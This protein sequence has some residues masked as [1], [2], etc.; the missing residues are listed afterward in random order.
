[1]KLLVGMIAG[2]L[3]GARR[4]ENARLTREL[5]SARAGSTRVRQRGRRRLSEERNLIARGD[6]LLR[7]SRV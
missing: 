1:M 2:A 6:D 4:A 3:T 7:Q 5:D